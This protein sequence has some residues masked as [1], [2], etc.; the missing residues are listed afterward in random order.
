[1]QPKHTIMSFAGGLVM[2]RES[3]KRHSRA[4]S[5]TEGWGQVT[6][7]PSCSPPTDD[8]VILLQVLVRTKWFSSHQ[9]QLLQ[10]KMSSLSRVICDNSDDISRAPSNAFRYQPVSEFIDC[11]ELPAVDLSLWG[12]CQGMPYTH[13]HT[14]TCM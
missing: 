9:T 12:D 10:L 7:H 13:T 8:D 3:S 2:W 5:Q 11:S 1:M 4:V 14:H 6:T